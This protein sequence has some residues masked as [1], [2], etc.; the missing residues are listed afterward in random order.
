MKYKD[1]LKGTDSYFGI[2][3]NG[4][5]QTDKEKIQFTR[6]YRSI[7]SNERGL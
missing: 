1:I 2:R 7:K 6:S 3:S 5:A 4:S